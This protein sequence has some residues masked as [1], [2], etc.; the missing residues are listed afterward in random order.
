MDARHD[1]GPAVGRYLGALAPG[2]AALVRARVALVGV[3]YDGGVSLRA[4]ARLAPRAIREASESIETYCP[5]LDMDLLDEPPVDLGDL[6]AAPAGAS[7]GQVV[8]RL[9]GQLGE[10]PALPRLV[11]GGDHLVALAAIVNLLARH[12]NLHVL[13]ID[14]HMDLRDTWKGEKHSHATVMR[15][16]L[17]AMGEHGRLLQWGIRS[18]LRQEFQVAREDSRIAR[19]ENTA[20]A[21][22][23]IAADLARLGHPVYI[24]LDADGIDPS[25]I[26]G[27]GN[28]EPAGLAFADVEAAIV[29]FARAG[30]RLVGADL[31]EIAPPLDTSGIS[32]VA[33]ARLARTLLLAL[34]ASAPG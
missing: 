3:Q 31:V 5:K 4:G 20:A 34:R 24:T 29:A 8:E 30:G 14:A 13:Q 11:L 1:G 15:R 6:P 16:V 33:G 32:V 12:P 10:L 9:R 21:G 28:P 18:G 26:P 23:E 17:D 2:D 27:T 19:V 7:T 22:L 25:E